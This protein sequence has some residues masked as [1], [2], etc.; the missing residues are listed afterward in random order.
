MRKLSFLVLPLLGF[1]LSAQA[2]WAQQPIGFASRNSIPLYLDVVDAST[3]W[4]VSIQDG[5]YAAP[6]AARTTN[7]GQTWTVT[8]LPALVA[9]EE[10]VVALSAVSATAAWVVTSINTVGPSGIAARILH[11]ADGGQTWVRQ[12]GPAVLGSPDSYPGFIRFF[13][14][15]EGVA[16]G[17][18]LTPNG[19]FELYTTANAG[20]TWT[21]VPTP[22][23]ATVADENI[24]AATALGN[25]AWFAT[26]EGRVFRSVN[27]GVTWAVSQVPGGLSGYD[28]LAS[29]AFRDGQNGLFSLLDTGLSTNHLLFAT[30][31]GGTTWAAV[32][33][34]GPLHGLGL[35]AVPGTSQYVSTGLNIMEMGRSSNDQGSSYTR[36]NGLTW[37]ALESQ[38]DH[39]RVEFVSPTAGYS[40]GFPLS[41][42]TPGGVNKFTSTV[43]GARTDAALQAGLRL[44]PNPAV[45]GRLT[46]QA[47][48]AVG[49]AQVRVLDAQG[50]V[51]S[52]QSWA[53]AAPL[54]L[55]LSR[56]TAGLYVLEVQAATGTARQ[57]LV[58]P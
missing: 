51:V 22:P 14:A 35:S 15:T 39:L 24:V 46:L 57:K 1:G 16:G 32:P 4:T 2:Q 31:N 40:G 37:T 49:P 45:D 23:T 17:R 25:S 6:Q 53:G 33:Y 48:Q 21:A 5:T 56:A 11:T 19:P 8:T 7:G 3:V 38:I 47:A 9:N 58:L 18:N 26:S 44:F 12:G 13:S 27:K 36:N 29:L 54:P 41:A 52:E 50:R 55:D 42:T 34:T 43:L 30:T 10:E 28:G 20:Q